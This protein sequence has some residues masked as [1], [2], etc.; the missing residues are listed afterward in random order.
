MARWEGSSAAR[1][2][3]RYWVAARSMSQMFPPNG[4]RLSFPM[5]VASA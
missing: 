3:E 2:D 1:V 5:L 4:M